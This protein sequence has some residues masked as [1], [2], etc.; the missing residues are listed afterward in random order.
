[1][2]PPLIPDAASIADALTKLRRW[3]ID[4]DWTGDDARA[5]EIRAEIARLE[6]LASYGETHDL[7][8]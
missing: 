7:P 1:M 8:F 4:A 2:P 3:L 5:D 6:M